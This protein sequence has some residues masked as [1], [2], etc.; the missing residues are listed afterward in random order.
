MRKPTHESYDTPDK[1]HPTKTH[2]E[3]SAEVEEFLANGGKIEKLPIIKR[4]DMVKRAL[5][6][7]QKERLSKREEE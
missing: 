1:Q 5:N 4:D 7:A 3:I 2:E 6:R